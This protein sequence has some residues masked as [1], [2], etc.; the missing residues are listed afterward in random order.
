MPEFVLNIGDAA[1]VVRFNL[2]SPFVRGY[3]EAAF[4]TSTG[5]DFEDEGLG[6]GS[7][8]AD[9]APASVDSIIADCAGFETVAAPLLK[10]A[11]SRGFEEEQA[12]R[13]F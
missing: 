2:L 6:E 7:S 5:P 11:Y 12:G 13:D 4:F 9:L 8:F 1:A 3:I 10:L